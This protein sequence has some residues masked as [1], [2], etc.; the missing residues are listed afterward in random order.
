MQAAGPHESCFRSCR[1]WKDSKSCEATWWKLYPY[2]IRKT[3]SLSTLL[4]TSPFPYCLISSLLFLSE[5]HLPSFFQQKMVPSN[6]STAHEF[7]FSLKHLDPWPSPARRTIRSSYPSGPLVDRLPQYGPSP[8][9]L[10]CPSPLWCR[11]DAPP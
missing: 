1:V 6:D 8:S 7:R 5:T 2:M 11:C 10:S 9:Q 4:H 3:R